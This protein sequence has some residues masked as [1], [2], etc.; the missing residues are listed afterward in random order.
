[1]I[2]SLCCWFFWMLTKITTYLPDINIDLFFEDQE[3]VNLLLKLS[4]ELG[5]LLN[6][7]IQLVRLPNQTNALGNGV[8]NFFTQISN[9]MKR[10]IF[11]HLTNYFIS[12]LFVT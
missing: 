2:I 4:D 6:V 9:L 10:D 3:V 7:R 1:M 11:Q 12:C 5:Q 8:L